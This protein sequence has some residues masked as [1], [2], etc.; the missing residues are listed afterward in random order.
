MPFAVY[1]GGCARCHDPKAPALDPEVDSPDFEATNFRSL[2][3]FV[4][5]PGYFEPENYPVL[6]VQQELEAIARS[7]GVE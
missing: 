1:Y 2:S 6:S 5:L 4:G 7:K 3:T